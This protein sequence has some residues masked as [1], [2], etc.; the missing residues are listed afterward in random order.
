MNNIALNFT[1]ATLL[2][3]SA[4]AAIACEFKAG[5]TKYLDYA[6]CR[7]GAENLQVIELPENSGWEQCIYQLRA[8]RPETLLA[9]TKEQ[10]GKEQ[11]SINDRSK[12]GN[13][14]YMTKQRCDTALKA[15]NA[16]QL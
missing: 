6:N 3:A 4:G 16:A 7:Y 9:V 12:I 2:T 10:D 15:F 13:P 1:I 14:C 8:F 5:E 11:V